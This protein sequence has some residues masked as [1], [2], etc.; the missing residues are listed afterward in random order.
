MSLSR[1]SVLAVSSAALLPAA[2]LPAA[3]PPRRPNILL[4]FPDQWRPDWGGWNSGLDIRTP[5]IDS[6][7]KRGIQFTYATVPSPLCAPSRAC[8]A[9]GCEYTKCGVASNAQD[10][11]LQQATFYQLLQ[12]SGYHTMACGKVDLHK[13]TLDWGVDGRRLTREWGFSSAIDNAG[14][15]DAP[16]SV[17]LAG[18]PTD[19]YMAMLQSRGLMQA[20]IDDFAHRAEYKD[21]FPTPLPDS[22]YCDNWI[23][24]NGLELLRRAP[25]N[26]PWFLQVNFTGPHGPMDITAAMESRA[27]R[28]AY[29]QPFGNNQFEPAV[30]TAI[31]Q[32]YTAMCENLDAWVGRY[33]DFLRQSR[34]LDHTI[35]VFSSDHGEMLGDHNRWGKTLPYQA[36][37][38]VPLIAAGPGIASGIRSSALASV[39]DL[40]ATALDYAGVEAPSSMDSRSLRGVLEGK[41]KRHREFLRS[42][43]NQWRMAWDGQYKLITG[44]APQAQANASKAAPA[45]SNVPPLLFDHHADPN[46]ANNVYTA[47]PEVVRRLTEMIHA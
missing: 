16:R 22:A 19:P 10:Y 46:E 27:R 13:K 17:Q 21:T 37:V 38:A 18:H 39:H 25:G 11:P 47:R 43:L 12:R 29:P 15:R 14:K 32:N 7:R 2:M 4:L 33:L 1:R 36:S 3:N 28:R 9:S 30:H 31:R 23:G 26:T 40:A 24:Q 34:Q 45:A 5:H 35:V 42:G 41:R 44:F 8:L 20:H 6:L